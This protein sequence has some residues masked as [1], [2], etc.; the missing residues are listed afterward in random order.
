MSDASIPTPESLLQDEPMIYLATV[1]GSEPR[2]RPVTLVESLGNLYV[3]T[4]TRCRKVREIK[5]NSN[6]E[7]VRLVEHGENRGYVRIAADASVVENQAVRE[8]VAAATSYFETF[9]KGASDPEFTL[10]QI[11]PKRIAY[12]RPGDDDESNIESLRFD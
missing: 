6:V 3:L 1:E 9:W 7:I 12:L 5:E 8:S 4:S 11:R 2:V 10:I